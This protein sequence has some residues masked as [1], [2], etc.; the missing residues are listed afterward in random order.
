MAK[1]YKV[2]IQGVDGMDV[3]IESN[4][5]DRIVEFATELENRERVRLNSE[6]AS[7]GFHYTVPKRDTNTNV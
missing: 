7:L 3:T 2:T 1:K 4:D 6:T 5:F